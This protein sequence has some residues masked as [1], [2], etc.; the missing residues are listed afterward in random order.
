MRRWEGF[1]SSNNWTKESS[2]TTTPSNKNLVI[3]KITTTQSSPTTPSPLYYLTN[4]TNFPIHKNYQ[5]FLFGKN[6]K[7]PERAVFLFILAKN[8]IGAGQR[9]IFLI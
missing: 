3:S 8:I 7:P 1:S 9:A 2:P 6:V 5:S 4:T